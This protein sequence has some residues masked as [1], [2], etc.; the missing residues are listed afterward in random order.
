[1]SVRPQG[2]GSHART[3]RPALSFRAI[4]RCGSAEYEPGLQRHHLLPRQL[5]SKD[6]FGTMFTSIG[7][8]NLGF[9]DFRKN[10]LLLPSKE[11]TAIRLCLPLHRGPHRQYNEMVIERVGQ[12]E[13]SWAESRTDD[14]QAAMEDALFRL[15]LLQSALRKR[16]LDQR[17]RIILNR[18]DPVGTGFDFSTLDAM[19]DELWKAT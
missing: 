14:P 8:Q 11:E 12:I 13:A 3:P 4:N 7:R 16:L 6:Y 1:M 2:R 10:G 9:D 15:S 19:A 17:R 18:K 5:L